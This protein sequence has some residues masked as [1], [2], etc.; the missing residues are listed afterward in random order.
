E[1]KLP[2]R[3]VSEPELYRPTHGVKKVLVNKWY[4]VGRVK[5]NSMVNYEHHG[6]PYVAEEIMNEANDI[7]VETVG[8]G[9]TYE[10]NNDESGDESDSDYSDND[11]EQQVYD[12]LKS[13]TCPQVLLMRNN[14]FTIN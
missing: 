12:K 8:G 2:S 9:A 1:I 14:R 4:T 10:V 6:E 3:Q 5:G 11:E 13:R 7:E